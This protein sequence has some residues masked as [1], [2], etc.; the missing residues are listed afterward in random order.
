M[1]T[2]KK[3]IGLYDKTINIIKSLKEFDKVLWIGYSADY[4]KNGTKSIFVANVKGGVGK[5]T[6]S[7][8]LARALLL[9]WLQK[10]SLLST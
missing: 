3:N 2:L 7:I 9:K 8:M 1:I 5:S 4:V 10:K 6:L